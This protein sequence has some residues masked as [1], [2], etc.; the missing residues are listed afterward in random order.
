MPLGRKVSLGPGTLCYMGTQKK[1]GT[2]P[3]QI[4]G[5]CLLWPYGRPSQLL[6]STYLNLFCLTIYLKK[7]Q[8]T[9][10]YVDYAICD[11]DMAIWHSI[12]GIYSFRKYTYIWI[13]H[14]IRARCSYGRNVCSNFGKTRKPSLELAPTTL[15]TF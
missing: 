5:P 4:F 6:V 8:N 9:T 1:M 3:P 2:A 15:A 12:K 11:T 10:H 13:K 7:L 14:V